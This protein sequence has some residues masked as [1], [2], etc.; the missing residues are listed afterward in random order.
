MESTITIEQIS[1][2]LDTKIDGLKKDLEISLESKLEEKLEEKLEKKLDE[3]LDKK[4]DEKL[5]ERLEVKFNEKLEP[6][7]ERLDNLDKRLTKVEL[8]QENQ[9]LPAINELTSVYVS[10]YKNFENKT[11]QINSFEE[12]AKV[13]RKVMKIVVPQHSEKLQEH[14]KTLE[15]HTQSLQEHHDKLQEHSETLEKIS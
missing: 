8:T 5:D 10:T 4:L 13:M 14:S 7:Y 11:E 9:I 2:L 6:I 1:D 3:K 12:I 15:E